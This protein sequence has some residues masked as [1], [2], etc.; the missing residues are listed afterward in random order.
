MLDPT[1]LRLLEQ[2]I[3]SPTKLQLVL[4]FNEDSHLE[5]TALQIA[6]RAYRDVW[7]VREALCELAEDGIV[8]AVPGRDEPVFRY[9]PS[10]E[11]ADALKRLF[12]S[13]NEP[14]ERDQIQRAVRQIAGDA[15]YRRAVRRGAM[16]EAIA[17]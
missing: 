10:Q 4:L 3:D 12:H 14:L 17:I 13:Y 5:G 15:P 2:A 1:I 11:R 16:F 8:L 7:S 6:Q 9:Q